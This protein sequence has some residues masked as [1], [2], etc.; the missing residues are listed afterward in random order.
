MKTRNKLVLLCC[1]VLL[2]TAVVPLIHAQDANVDVYGRTL[3]DDAAPYDMQVWTEMCRSDSTQTAF[4]A[5]TTV[6]QRICQPG[7]SDLFADSLVNLDENLN[8]IP[9]AADSWEAS[10]DGLTWTFHLHPDQ[11][12]S[13]GTPLT[14]N[15]WVVT[16]QW[17]ADG[18]NAY[19]FSWMW[20]GVIKNWSEAISKEVKPDQI[21]MTAVDDNT[22]AITT[23][24]PAPYLPATMFFWPPLQAKALTE[25]GPNYQLD[26]ATS[27]SSGPYILK[28]FKPGESILLEANPTYTGFR[29]PYLKQI[30]GLYGDKLNGSFLAFQNRDIDRVS[31]EFLT[32][33]DF[34][35]IKGD[36]TMLSHYL[37][38]PGDFRTDYLVMDTYTPPFDNL[39]VRQAF[40]HAVDREN[41]VSK[42]INANFNLA[43]PAYSFLMPGFPA[44]DTSGAL[45]AGQEYDCDMAK[46]LLADAGYPNGEGFPALEMK[47]RG[48]SDFNAQRFIAAASSISDCLGVQITINNM[49][50]ATYMT[51]LNA[52]PTGIQFGAVSYGMDYL[53]P[54][55]MLGVWVSTGR[56]SWRNAD[57]DKLVTD[58]GVFV[59]DP[60]TRFQMYKDAEKILVD[61]VG[62]IFLDHRIQ[63]D[64]FQPYI[65][66]DCFR[67]NAQ[68]V[69]SWEW[70][71]DWCW[72]SIYVTKDVANYDTFR[73]K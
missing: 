32:P 24:G 71:N 47:L 60:A 70:G 3:P 44:S 54:A 69:S 35:I 41:I 50:F 42:V 65:A 56:H 31:Y 57:F 33:A 53:D 28:E 26:P 55:N 9:A 12:W 1:V 27:V 2:L 63:G 19:D 64:L 20:Q 30:R 4:M 59:G 58:A 8:L 21:G 61:D 5:A 73:T 62:G 36:E 18:N 37:P 17:M 38:N 15:D 14:A 72:G 7:A 29:K 16:Y 11:V 39:K 49:E 51:A 23:V 22:L 52:K 13:D 10:A 48:E 45:H 43:I 34:E 40:A 46:Q 6:Y 68:G 67:K 25:H 66:G